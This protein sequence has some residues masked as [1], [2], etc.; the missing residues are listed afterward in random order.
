MGHRA[1]IRLTTAV[2]GRKNFSGVLAGVIDEM[3]Q[4][5]VDNETVSLNYKDITRAR[6]INY[7][8]ER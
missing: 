5:Q 3:V 2:E 8:G 1:K 7:N 6:L 4:L